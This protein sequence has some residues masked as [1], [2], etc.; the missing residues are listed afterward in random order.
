M[1]MTEENETMLGIQA[2]MTVVLA[3]LISTHPEPEK[4]QL[5]IARLLEHVAP[6]T[7]WPTLNAAQRVAAEKYVE[8]LQR[9]Q[10]ILGEIDPLAQAG[11]QW[12]KP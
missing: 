2:G 5:Q 12:R 1:A 9:I 3:A 8:S 11:F 7:L 6:R 4:L 10:P